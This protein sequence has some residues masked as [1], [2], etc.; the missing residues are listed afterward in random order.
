MSM[1]SILKKVL[2]DVTPTEKERKE[3]GLVLEKVL[4]ATEDVTTPRRLSHVLAGSFVRDTWMPDKKEFDLFIMFPESTSREQLEKEGLEIGKGIVKKLK[5]KHTIAYAEHP[6]VRAR[7]LGYDV[8]IVPAY[9]V[10]SAGNIK[11]AVDRTPF[12]NRWLSAYLP[13]ELSKEVRLLKQF[14][15]SLDIYGSDAK[16]QGFSGY[17]CELFIVH[18]N[19]FRSFLKVAEKWEA[20][21]VFIDHMKHHKGQEDIKEMRG[22]FRDQPLIVIDPVDPK[23]NVAAVISPENFTALVKACREFLKRPSLAYFF[24]P[25]TRPSIKKLS[26]IMKERKTRLL[27][28][29]FKRPGVIDDVL[30]PQLRR[31]GRRLSDI[32]EEYEFRVIGWSVFGNGKSFILLELGVWEQKGSFATRL[33]LVWGIYT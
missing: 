24:R 21:E 27:L 23:R 11:S 12:H 26:K 13:G 8:D 15:K 3:T 5:G 28:V 18:Y 7:I 33:M 20:G 2:K 9:G 29:S 30:W 14:C 1:D 10:K 22:R 19:S 16:T 25:E 6:Y 4:K 31:T 17:L 32:L